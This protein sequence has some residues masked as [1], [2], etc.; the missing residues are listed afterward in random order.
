MI[1][2]GYPYKVGYSWAPP[3]RFQRITQVL[4]QAQSGNKLDVADMQRL[5][6]DVHSLPAVQLID[7]VAR[8][9]VA[10]EKVNPAAKLLLSW[11]WQCR[12]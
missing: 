10:Q 12:S 5:Q 4:Q 3:Y 1:P 11:N 2:D 8:S 7:S 6:T 9:H